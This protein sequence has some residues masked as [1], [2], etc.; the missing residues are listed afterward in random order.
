[1]AEHSQARMAMLIAAAIAADAHDPAEIPTLVDDKDSLPSDA[2]KALKA[3]KP[4]LFRVPDATKM[5]RKEYRAAKS[6]TFR[7]IAASRR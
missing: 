1:M 2:V 5:T 4:H 3:A 7:A 6:A